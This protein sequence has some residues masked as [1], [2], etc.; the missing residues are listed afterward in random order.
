MAITGNQNASCG[1]Q[2]CPET[3]GAM[4]CP[5]YTP[6]PN[7]S[8]PTNLSY[9]DQ[10]GEVSNSNGNGFQIP[11]VSTES[12]GLMTPDMLQQ[13]GDNAPVSTNLSYDPETGSVSN[14]NGDG[15][16]I[17]DVSDENKGL[18]TPEMLADLYPDG[19]IVEGTVEISGSDAIISGWIG[20][21]EQE[22]VTQS[23]DPKVLPVIPADTGYYRTDRVVLWSNGDVEIVQG[24]PGTE[25][26][27][28]PDLEEGMLHLDFIF[29]YGNTIQPPA[30]ATGFVTKESQLSN[31]I[32]NTGIANNL[33][34]NVRSRYLI[35]GLIT[36]IRGLE[37]V[38][39]APAEDQ[40]FDGQVYTFENKSGGAITLPHNH[41]SGQ[42]KFYFPWEGAFVLDDKDTARFFWDKVNN[43]LVYLGSSMDFL[44]SQVVI[45]G[46]T[47]LTNAHHGKT[48][49]VSANTTITVPAGL[50]KNFTCNVDVLPT[51]A[52]AFVF[53]GTTV[54]GNA[55]I[56]LLADKMATLYQRGTSNA[57][58]LK[59]ET[60]A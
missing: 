12:P 5:D 57:Y 47:T 24:I 37:S 33:S 59:G 45:S 26:S 30:T 13:L 3:P 21:Y 44:F 35:K 22:I 38:S 16:T 15:F 20:R 17:P 41:A 25:S 40:N 34:R 36:E 31:V 19:I 32:Y 43:W 8:V 10:T 27:N 23:S 50:R 9:N 53:S 42:I 6:N 46:N 14:D 60:S 7:P 11:F 56:N 51:Y 52:A 39:S 29:V 2:A 28:A 54:S 58:R 4:P 55:G 49:L 48:L 1:P 18:M